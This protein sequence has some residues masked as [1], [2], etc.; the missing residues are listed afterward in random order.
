MRIQGVADNPGNHPLTSASG[1][2]AF[3]VWLAYFLYVAFTFGD[4]LL[5]VVIG[6]VFG[7]V[8]C[9]AVILNFRYWRSAVVLA[10][11]AYLLLY[12]IRIGRMIAMTADAPLLPALSL[13]YNMSWAVTAGVFQEKGMAAGLIHAYFEFVM[14][15]LVVAIIVAVLVSSRRRVG[16]APA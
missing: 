4:A 1:A 11:A 13:Y 14:P 7:L 16:A 10:S 8:A 15:A 3:A 2:F 12:V 6:G 9:L 5:S